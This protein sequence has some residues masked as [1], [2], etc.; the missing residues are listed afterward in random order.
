MDPL[1][2]EADCE[3]KERSLEVEKINFLQVSRQNDMEKIFR[4]GSEAKRR[5]SIVKSMFF[6]GGGV[7]R[8]TFLLGAGLALERFLER[9]IPVKDSY[10]LQKEC[11]GGLKK[12]E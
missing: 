6:G 2:G 5:I 1:E 4:E 11:D 3:Q 12:I 10:Y 8:S 7:P 9:T